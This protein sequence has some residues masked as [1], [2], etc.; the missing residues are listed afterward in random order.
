[1]CNEYITTVGSRKDLPV[2]LPGFLK[3]EKKLK[4]NK[5]AYQ[6]LL[7]SQIYLKLICAC[8][9]RALKDRI[10]RRVCKFVLSG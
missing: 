5:V 7:R 4:V 3:K 2:K 8:L 10:S 6:V 1:M 9:K